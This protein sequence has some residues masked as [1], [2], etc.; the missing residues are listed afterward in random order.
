MSG[1]F[2]KFPKG[3][4]LGRLLTLNRGLNR[5]FVMPKRSYHFTSLPDYDMTSETF[6]KGKNKLGCYM[7]QKEFENFYASVLEELGVPLIADKITSDTITETL[8]G[9]YAAITDIH[10]QITSPK[11]DIH[12][13]INNIGDQESSAPREIVWPAQYS[14]PVAEVGGLIRNVLYASTVG[15]VERNLKF[16]KSIAGDIE[17]GEGQLASV[18]QYYVGRGPRVPFT[19]LNFLLRANGGTPLTDEALEDKSAV[20]KMIEKY[21]NGILPG[22]AK[23]FTIDM[24]KK[25]LSTVHVQSPHS[26]AVVQ[27]PLKGGKPGYIGAE[28]GRPSFS[29]VNGRLVSNAHEQVVDPAVFQS[30]NRRRLSPKEL[31]KT[32]EEYRKIETGVT[33]EN[34]YLP[35]KAVDYDKLSADNRPLVEAVSLVSHEK[36]SGQAVYLS[37]GVPAAS[38]I[39]KIP[40]AGRLARVLY[41]LTGQYPWE[42]LRFGG[43]FA[44]DA[45]TG[46]SRA[47]EALVI[48]GCDIAGVKPQ[49]LLPVLSQLDPYDLSQEM[50]ESAYE[51]V[52]YT[53]LTESDEV[54][55]SIF[56]KKAAEEYL[57]LAAGAFV[58]MQVYKDLL[59]AA[60]K[61]I[62]EAKLLGETDVE[63]EKVRDL[64]E[65]QTRNFTRRY[66]HMW[67]IGAAVTINLHK[68]YGPDIFLDPV[69]EVGPGDVGAPVKP[70]SGTLAFMTKFVTEKRDALKTAP[71]GES[72]K[73]RKVRENSLD[74]AEKSLKYIANIETELGIRD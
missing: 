57:R 52:L 63:A 36:E 40:H 11:D 35:D 69:K 71:D 30:M 44:H 61:C 38:V 7:E 74:L 48:F 39:R 32:I 50:R 1:L 45:L 25:G 66:R 67:A 3:M 12:A 5:M 51:N 55:S 17:D 28:V 16:V 19:A 37:D 68:T 27:Y 10:E 13:P 54:S 58:S 21:L 56:S 70:S 6:R 15:E 42:A 73:S 2:P 24:A 49:E 26:S 72:E 59:R 23:S 53:E 29:Y 47:C 22:A 65:S 46:Q 62:R 41:F 60:E 20:T 33:V 14:D 8:K 4:A 43:Y 34:F 18:V 9:K 31:P 64:V